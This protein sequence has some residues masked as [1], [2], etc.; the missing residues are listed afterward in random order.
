RGIL[1]RDLKPANILLDEKGEPHV[2]DFGLAKRVTTEADNVTQAP[3]LTQTGAILGTPSYMA[4]E[5]AGGKQALT[6]AADIY[7][8]AAILYELTTG[9]PPFHG[10]TPLDTLLQVAEQEAPR[11]R[12]L[13]PE[14]DYDL[15]TICLKCLEKD[16]AKRYPSAQALADD[17]E[18]WLAGEP[19]LGRR[20]SRWERTWKW[21]RR[22]RKLSALYGTAATLAAGLLGLAALWWHDAE[23]RAEAVQNLGQA[24]RDLEAAHQEKQ[25]AGEDVQRLQYAAQAEQSKLEKLQQLVDL[26]KAKAATLRRDAR[27]IVYAAD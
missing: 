8:L 20:T 5:Q 19:I 1:H 10:D 14:I 15:E 21:V 23:L 25:A 27:H 11:P 24:R 26:E 12:A 4:P 7:S 9:Q 3:A 16:P 13:N 18:R 17:L 6:T 22:N 2:S